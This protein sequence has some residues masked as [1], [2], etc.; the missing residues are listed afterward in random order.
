MIFSG[1]VLQ[2][3]LRHWLISVLIASRLNQVVK[4]SA[5]IKS[6]K[7]PVFI[8]AFSFK[9]SQI[10]FFQVVEYMRGAG[11]SPKVPDIPDIPDDTLEEDFD[12]RFNM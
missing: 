5:K 6:L 8:L 11:I 3:I 7:N 2:E 10:T 12:K 4:P 1:I 9:V